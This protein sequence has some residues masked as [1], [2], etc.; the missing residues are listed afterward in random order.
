[1]E[2]QNFEKKLTQMTKPEVSELKHQEMLANAIRKAKDKSVVSWWWISIPGYIIATLLM[3]T[4]FMPGTTLISNISDMVTREKYSSI[5]FFLIVPI[6]FIIINIISIRKVHFLSGSP[7]TLNFLW[8]VWFN[9]LII[10]FSI[11][12]LIIYA[13]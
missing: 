10:I 5:L 11:L 8:E 12:I 3:K 6:A 13:L 1:M 9:V 7:K 2:M 4:V